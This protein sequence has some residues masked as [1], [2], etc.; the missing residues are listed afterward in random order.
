[1]DEMTDNYLIVVGVDGSEGGR[2]ALDWAVTEAANRGGA[3][4][5]VVAWRWDDVE[6]HPQTIRPDETHAHAERILERELAALRA[7]HGA[8]HP[9]AAE[10]VEGRPAEV[11]ADAARTADLLVLGSHGHGRL[12]HTVLGS[13][14]EEVIRRAPCPV[15]VIPEP[16]PSTAPA[17]PTVRG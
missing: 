7:R 17:E 4:Q 12:L 5:A 16:V 11:L 6:L 14:S 2:R 1:M 3:V 15:V 9:V 8:G 13:V 10:I